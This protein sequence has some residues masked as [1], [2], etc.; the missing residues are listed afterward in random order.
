M[1]FKADQLS[2][3]ISQ[4]EILNDISIAVEN[5][6]I[7]GIV[8]PNG[9]GK[10]TLVKAVSQILKPASGSVSLNELDILACSCE[11]LSQQLAVVSQ[12]NDLC[13]D[14]TVYQMVLMGRSG[15]RKFYERN[16]REDR[17]EVYKAL[18]TVGM[19][20]FANQSYLTLSG[21]EKQRVILA[22]ALVQNPSFMILDE[23]TNHLDIKHQLQVLDIVKSLNI[24]ILTVLHDLELAASYCDKIYVIHQGSV[25]NY[26]SPQKVI[27]E[28]MIKDVY[29]VSSKIYANPINGELAIV[30]FNN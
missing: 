14:F 5:N 12:F 19:K 20:S 17:H 21:G 2:V 23:P 15:C 25:Y 28:T 30:Y 24:G 9:C 26:G 27:T 18:D 16:D 4:K 3:T 1:S 8:G 13:F 7:V 11:E 22:R 29:D 6:E 10:S